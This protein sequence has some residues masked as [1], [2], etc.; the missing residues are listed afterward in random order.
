MVN[1]M[2]VTADRS[3]FCQVSNTDPFVAIDWY[4][5]LVVSADEELTPKLQAFNGRHLP[6]VQHILTAKCGDRLR[7]AAIGLCCIN[8]AG[9]QVICE[10][11]L[12]SE[13]KQVAEE[14]DFASN[15]GLT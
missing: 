8:Y 5:Y 11:C 12:R 15:S 4:I 2:F 14:L 1:Q 10:Y 9:T 13:T 3:A 7:R 6:Q